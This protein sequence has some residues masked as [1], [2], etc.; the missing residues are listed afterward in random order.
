MAWID[1]KGRLHDFG[2]THIM[3]I[4]NYPTKFGVTS[5]EIVD[6]YYKYD[7]KM[8]IEGRARHDI[9]RK[10]VENGF[11][12][13]RFHKN[14]VSVTVKDETAFP[15]SYS[16]VK[17]AQYLLEL[18]KDKYLPLRIYSL[19]DENL[20]EQ[21]LSHVSSRRLRTT[22]GHSNFNFQVVLDIRDFGVDV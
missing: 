21:T 22:Y 4:I 17:W 2:S 12:R 8:G 16:T 19:C 1:P 5:Q 7:E 18:T 6:A 13:I 14:Y 11:T 3:A 9:V 15:W 20:M 10:V